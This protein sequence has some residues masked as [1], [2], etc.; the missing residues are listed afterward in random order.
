MLDPELKEYSYDGINR[1]IF[2]FFKDPD[3]L[4]FESLS[5]GNPFRLS[6]RQL[7]KLINR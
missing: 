6:T 5:E 7:E 1:E 3:S 2:P 4:E